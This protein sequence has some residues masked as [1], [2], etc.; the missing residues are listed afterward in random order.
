MNAD[1]WRSCGCR[2]APGRRGLATILSTL[3]VLSIGLAAVPASAQAASYTCGTRSNYFDGRYQD[4]SRTSDRFEG[5]S[6]YIVIRSAGL[7]NTDTDRI[8]NFSNAWSAISGQSVC[9]VAQSGYERGGGNASF[10]HFAQIALS[11]PQITTVYGGNLV[12]SDVGGR[13]TYRSLFNTGCSCLVS[14]V[15]TSTFLMSNFNPYSQWTYP[16]SA[17]FLGEVGYRESDVPGSASA[18]AQF[19]GIGG[20]LS[21]N[22]QLVAM[23]CDLTTKNNNPN[24][25]H[26]QFNTCENFEIWSA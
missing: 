11:C 10:R 14:T 16:F 13:H 23:P 20:Q 25:W 9:Q 7:C 3:L 17:Q 19:T 24:V 21:S 22:H 12:V 4:A 18:H 8:N 26:L 15:D 1:M 5:S 6:A 2:R